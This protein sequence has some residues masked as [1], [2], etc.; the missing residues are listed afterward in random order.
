MAAAA[1]GDVASGIILLLYCGGNSFRD[2]KL[3]SVRTIRSNIVSGTVN[4]DGT[5][6][7]TMCVPVPVHTYS[8]IMYYI[9]IYIEVCIYTFIYNIKYVYMW[10]VRDGERTI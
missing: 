1:K 5:A 7:A 6:A 8:C 4:A 9:F 10:R 2:P 3:Q